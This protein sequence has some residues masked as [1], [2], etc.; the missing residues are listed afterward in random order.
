MRLF[1][2][3][4]FSFFSVA[5]FA[6]VPVLQWAKAFNDHPANYRTSSNGRTVGVDDQGNVY[7]AGLFEHTVDF[8]P[9]PGLFTLTGG[10]SQSEIGI[11]ISKLDANGNFVW[12]KQ[13]PVV[14]EFAQIEMKVDRA[15]NIYLAAYFNQPTDMDPG[16]GAYIL[17]PIGAK[18]AFVIKMDPNGNLVWVKQFGGPGDTVPASTVLDLDKDNNVILC[19]TFNNTVDFDP[20]PG[21]YNLTSTAHIQS[22]IVK[23]NNNGD[24]IWAKQFG[25]STVVYSG[26][27]IDDVKCDSQ[28]NICLVG[29]FSGSCDY[30][31]GPV[32]YNLTSSP[33][34][35]KDGFVAKLDPNG[36]FIWAKQ[37]ASTT[38]GYND[39]LF[40]KGIDVDG[41]NNIITTGYFI[42]TRD[43]DP[44]TGVYPLISGGYTDCFILK[45][46]EQGQFLWAKRI[47]D[48]DYDTGNDVAIDN[49]NNIYE[50]G[51]FG[52]SVDF[53]PGP[54][55]FTI[56]SSYYGASALVKLDPNGE[57]IY[58]IAFQ[59]ISY[60]T[61][62]FRRMAI[63]A[64]KNIYITGSV[65]GIVDVD[66]GPKVYPLSSSSDASPFVLKLGRCTDVTTST[67]DINACNSYTLNNETFDSTGTYI[68][69]IPNTSGCDSMI[70][71]HLT[72]NKKF[73]QQTKAICQGDVFFA[74]GANQGTAGTYID[75]LKTIQG[76]DSIVTTY[77]T[78]NPQPLLNLGPDT[79]LCPGNTIL[80]NAKKG[81]ATYQW[82]D[83]S[84][85]STFIVTTTGTYFITTSN[86]CGRV[87][88]DTI[89]VSPHPPIP[90]D[91]GPDLSKC[92]ADSLTISLP[93]GFFNYIWTPSYNNINVTPNAQTVIVFPSTDTIYVVR[94]EKTPGC[95][96]YD[97]IR[98]KVYTSPKI[99]LGTDTS[100]CGSDSLTLN[101][102]VGFNK[103]LWNTGSPAQQITVKS[104]GAYSVTATTIN[105]C[106][107]KDTLVI[108]AVNQNPVVKLDHDSTLCAGTSRV[109]NAGSFSTYLW[110][111][112]NTS[113]TISVNNVGVY[114]VTV[115]D[116]NN[117]KGSDTTKIVTM[118]PALSR[119]LPGDT[120]VCSYGSVKL[121][122][123]ITYSK[124][125]WNTNA[126]T[127]AIT[128]TQPGVYWLEVKDANNCSGRDS[129]TVAQKDCMKGFYIPNAFTPNH[130]GKNDL[131]RPMLLGRVML[132][133]F[134]IYNQWGEM[135]FK[136]T[137]V[138]KGWDGIYKKLPQNT[139]VFVWT[140]KYQFENEAVKLE[141]G[142]VTLIR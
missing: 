142:I 16:P 13:I 3:S 105:N 129:I 72:I 85:D 76:C 63:D 12:A 101:A 1:L 112:G 141:R 88:S 132:Y 73:T 40:S 84:T 45:L 69:I 140:C 33:G 60:G 2:L 104:A 82:Q 48:K 59:S 135:V 43:F 127:P 4:I 35:L 9:G 133:E 21:I 55:N 87:F 96:A 114:S 81:F 106:T 74:G 25:N 117:C 120:S 49:D 22:F 18:D 128:I 95:F 64:V 65:S 91:L 92:N 103:Y 102:G 83:G 79:V 131:F 52:T 99:N 94:A 125:L 126:V 61:S 78:V 51:S 8:D 14:I 17:K 107:S 42:G 15:G 50:L 44:G 32:V 109:L 11:Y 139:F 28:G 27:V 100:L 29:E 66:P 6:Q 26:S 71:L 115:T 10:G 119:F 137:D 93:T 113:Q 80:L 57:F 38:G 77:L 98:I 23:L 5:I 70:T 20:G 124:Y 130:D 34:S 30:D 138:S 90:F 121:T 58:A 36:N 75:T 67:L 53:D 68:R 134:T 19:G 116:N 118:F 111:T 123:N 54:G 47:G 86:A 41:M 136:S 56:N 62:L 108:V 110:N 89:I 7:S 24:F 37:I 122:S 46:N 97:S 31:P 39:Y